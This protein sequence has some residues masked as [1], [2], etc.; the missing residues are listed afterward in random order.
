MRVRHPDEVYAVADH[1]ETLRNYWVR[2]DR[3]TAGHRLYGQN[4]IS[5]LSAHGGALP[6]YALAHARLVKG[7]FDLR[8]RDVQRLTLFFSPQMKGL[9]NIYDHGGSVRVRVN[10][11]R[12]IR[13]KLDRNRSVVLEQ[14]RARQDRA[15]L[16]WTSR[17]IEVSRH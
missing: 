4:E 14:A 5:R 1:E 10:R 3:A 16:F 2:I 9:G 12:F 13:V 7:A 8:T 11:S 15:R 17:T 6:G